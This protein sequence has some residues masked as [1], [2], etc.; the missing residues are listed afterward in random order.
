MRPHGVV[1]P[2]EDSNRQIHCEV[3]R[4][5]GSSSLS[6][7]YDEPEILRYSNRHF[8]P[9]GA[10]AGHVCLPKGALLVNIG[11]DS[12]VDEMAAAQALQT[13]HLDGYAAALPTREARSE[14]L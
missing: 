11:R 10:D 12:T 14:A 3:G 7:G 2:P 4:I 6:L 13:E 9:I 1:L 8:G 5:S